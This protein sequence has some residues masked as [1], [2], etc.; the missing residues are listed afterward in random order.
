MKKVALA[1]AVVL[2]TTN[3]WTGAPLLAVWVG[4]RV[5]GGG[6]PSMG[7]VGLVAVV[8]A[9]L[10]FFL[11]RLIARLSAAYDVASGRPPR[12]RQHVPWLRSMRGERPGSS[13][14]EQAALTVPEFILVASVA[15]AVLAFEVWFFFFSGSPIQGSTGR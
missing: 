3:V 6:A 4:S 8:L 12:V 14:N 9:V 1:V 5:Q 10:C 7:A 13:V 2:A 11:V 15:I